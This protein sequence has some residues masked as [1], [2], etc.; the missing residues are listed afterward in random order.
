MNWIDIIL[1]IPIAWLGFKGFKKGLIIEVFSLLALLSGIYGGIHFS[2]FTT[3]VLVD[4]LKF[5][6]DYMPIISFGVTFLLIVVAVYY[7]GKLLEKVIKMVALGIVNKI[8]GAV[9]GMVKAVLFLSLFLILVESIN[10]KV[11]FLPRDLT[12][13]SVLYE[14]VLGVTS[15]LFPAMRETRLWDQIDSWWKEH[16]PEL[17]ELPPI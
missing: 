16:R 17:P 6:S 13:E 4:D 9:F 5:T 2:E 3:R 10:N 1:I 15:T 7:T 11:E 14:P 12:S 8:A